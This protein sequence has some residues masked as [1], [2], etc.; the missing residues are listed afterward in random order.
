MDMITSVIYPHP[1]GYVFS[2]SFW[3]RIEKNSGGDDEISTVVNLNHR[4]S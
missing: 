2:Q 1:K 3:L 4:I